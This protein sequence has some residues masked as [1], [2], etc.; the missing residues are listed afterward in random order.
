MR[1][2]KRGARTKADLK[3]YHDMLV[4]TTAIVKRA[5]DKGQSL[6]QI[7]EKG[8]KGYEKWDGGF[9]SA[10]RWVETVYTSLTR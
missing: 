9:I 4:K 6:A 8:L 10:E 7:K 5:I 1:W 2:L 3:S